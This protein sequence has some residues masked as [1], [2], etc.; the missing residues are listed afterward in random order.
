MNARVSPDAYAINRF[1][2]TGPTGFRA[3]TMPDAPTRATRAEA[4][5]DELAWKEHA[6]KGT[7]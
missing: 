1:Q 3:A 6:R 7:T 4:E 5:A 2:A